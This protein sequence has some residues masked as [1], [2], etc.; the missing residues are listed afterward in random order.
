MSTAVAAQAGRTTDRLAVLSALLHAGAVAFGFFLADQSGS[1]S[2]LLLSG[3]AAL[4]LA[5]TALGWASVKAGRGA[6]V[7]G[8]VLVGLSVG[9]LVSALFGEGGLGMVSIGISMLFLDWLLF[10]NARRALS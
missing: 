8:V 2:Y 1:S 5:A 9:V 10:T 6:W 3:S 4:G 7:A